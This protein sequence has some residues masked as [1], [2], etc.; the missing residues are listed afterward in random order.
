MTYFPRIIKTAGGVTGNKDNTVVSYEIVRA[1]DNVVVFTRTTT[2][3]LVL[4]SIHKSFEMVRD[5]MEVFLV[6][7]SGGDRLAVAK[8]VVSNM[9]DT[10]WQK[11]GI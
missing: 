9:T 8:T 6:A 7:Q 10:D 2:L 3:H 5:D 1:S 11:Y 4:L